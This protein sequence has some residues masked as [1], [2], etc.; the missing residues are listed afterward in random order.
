[1]K[2]FILSILALF[3]ISAFAVNGTLGRSHALKYDGTIE[4]GT[5]EKLSINVKNTHSVAI[6]KG[7]AVVLDTSAD[8]GMSVI[9]STTAQLSP[10]CI[11]E[12]ACAVGA[13]CSCQ[14]YGKNSDAL[15]DASS[16]SATAGRRWYLSGVTAGYIAARGTEVATEQ[17]GGVFFDAS[18]AT[19]AVEVFIK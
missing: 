13:L 11:M 16:T 4:P 18:S 8:D 7:M 9:I 5:A 1:M 14:V 2:L 12:E 10:L 15:F 19:G 6:S 3:S 17:P